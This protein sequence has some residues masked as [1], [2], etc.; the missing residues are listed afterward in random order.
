MK[1]STKQVFCPHCVEKTGK[2]PSMLCA[3]DENGDI[4]IRCKNCKT[5]VNVSELQRNNKPVMDYV[6]RYVTRCF[7]GNKE[8]SDEQTGIIDW[9]ENSA[10]E[11]EAVKRFMQWIEGAT[12]GKIKKDDIIVYDGSYGDEQFITVKKE[13]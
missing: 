1:K 5:D 13:K 12:N 11:S 8:Y 9:E 2:R 10:E 4:I 6:I 3:E 7:G